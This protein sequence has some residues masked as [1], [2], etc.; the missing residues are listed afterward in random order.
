VCELS[1]AK[2]LLKKI[3]PV[4]K[5]KPEDRRRTRRLNQTPKIH[6]R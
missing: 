3:K 4:A 2:D 1:A 5:G 6:I